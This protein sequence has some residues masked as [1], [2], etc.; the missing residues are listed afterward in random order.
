LSRVAEEPYK[1]DE[2]TFLLIDSLKEY[3]C[4]SCLE[5]GIGK[6]YVSKELVKNCKFLIGTDISLNAIMVAKGLLAKEYKKGLIELVC[7]SLASPIKTNFDL[8]VF[9]PPYLP[10]NNIED[11]STDGLKG[12]LEVAK[13]FLRDAKRLLKKDGKILFVI[14]TL[15]DVEGIIKFAKSLGF[16][17]KVKRKK[18]IFMEELIVFEAMR[19]SQ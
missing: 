12:G 16:S 10:S 15:A 13:E 6:G 9:N 14:S 3:I 18:R 4:K 2:D 1:P 17:V 11:H 7:C 19:E 5:I 8:I